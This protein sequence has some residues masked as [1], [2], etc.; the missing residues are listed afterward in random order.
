MKLT[1]LFFFSLFAPIYERSQVPGRSPNVQSG[2]LIIAISSSIFAFLMKGRI[3]NFKGAH[4]RSLLAS[5]FRF[6]VR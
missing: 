5:N 3:V 1:V 6:L 2:F 4:F